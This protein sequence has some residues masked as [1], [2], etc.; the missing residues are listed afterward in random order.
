MIQKED[1]SKMYSR[2]DKRVIEFLEY[3]VLGLGGNI[4][5]YMKTNFD[6]LA[7]QLS[8]YYRAL[9]VVEEE[10]LIMTTQKGPRQ[11]PTMEIL[12]KCWSHIVTLLKECGVTKYSKTKIDRLQ[13]TDA[14]E[15]VESLVELLTK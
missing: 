5:D 12:Q 14:T 6:L 1:I 3:V 13:R 7:V 11:S 8:I 15:D 4:G 9:D 2:Y 10:P